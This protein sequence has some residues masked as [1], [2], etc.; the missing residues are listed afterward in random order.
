MFGPDNVDSL[1]AK[2]RVKHGRVNI[3]GTA[4]VGD[5]NLAGNSVKETIN[6]SYVSDGFGG[7]RGAPGV[8]SDN[9]CSNGYDL[10]DGLVDMPVVDETGGPYTDPATGIVYSSYLSCFEATATVVDPA[11][12]DPAKELPPPI[13]DGKPALVI[14][15]GGLEKTYS[16]PNGELHI[17]PDGS[18]SVT[19]KVFIK[20]SVS[21]GETDKSQVTYSGSGTLCTRSSVYLH[22]NVLPKTNFPLTDALGLLA[23][24]KI[25]LAT[26]AGD[27]QLKM[28]LAMYA[29]HRVIS[30][31]QSE[32]AG[33]MVSSY[34]QMSN[35]P[36]IYQ[37][38]ELAEHLPPGLPAREPIWI[39]SISVESWQEV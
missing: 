31:K 29:Q 9:G 6:G 4:S 26:G 25:E 15:K 5:P 7:N 35:V 37:V 38:P 39:K 18:F 22:C 12:Y 34:Y 20:G 1:G 3:S 2:L 13:L 32:I 8:F 28:S 11:L 19:G 24:D 23:G 14:Q 17:Y 16:G 36:S 21:F 10:G 27:A 30:Q 33:S